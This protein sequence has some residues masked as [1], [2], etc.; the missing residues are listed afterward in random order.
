MKKFFCAFFFFFVFSM[1]ASAQSEPQYPGA[2]YDYSEGYEAVSPTCHEGQ[3]E[4]IWEVVDRHSDALVPVDYVCRNGR[5]VRV[6][7]EYAGGRHGGPA[8]GC[9]E[10][11]HTTI[12]EQD[13][14]TD[15]SHPVRYVC[16]GGTWVRKY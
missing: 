16:R 6:N 7:G 4:R 15:T 2:D 12:I 5:F 3:R 10:G 14:F 13:L 9:R 1:V 8:P 11:S